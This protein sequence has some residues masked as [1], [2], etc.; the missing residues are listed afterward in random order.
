MVGG[1]SLST[2][3]GSNLL[4]TREL[5]RDLAVQP[6][7]AYPLQGIG[8]VR[9]LCRRGCATSMS[10]PSHGLEVL[11]PGPTPLYGRRGRQGKRF[12]RKILVLRFTNVPATDVSQFV[13]E[14]PDPG[15]D[16]ELYPRVFTISLDWRIVSF[17]SSGAAFDYWIASGCREV[18]YLVAY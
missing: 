18:Q 14:P 17:G 3:K 13:N 11:L 6:D 12:F 15:C 10:S 7:L 1:L 4:Q 9:G 16:S 8:W 5:Y 2:K